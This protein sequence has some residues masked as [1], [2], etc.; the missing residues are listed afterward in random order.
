MPF[1]TAAA[2]GQRM[3]EEEVTL[4]ENTPSLHTFLGIAPGREAPM[5]NVIHNARV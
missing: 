5:S 2:R 4:C 1:L 3:R